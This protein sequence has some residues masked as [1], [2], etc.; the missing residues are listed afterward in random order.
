MRESVGATALFYIFAVFL[1]VIAFIIGFTINYMSAYR[2]NNFL[3]SEIE[4]HN[5]TIR[6]NV[7]DYVK[8]NYGYNLHVEGVDFEVLPVDG[9]AL[10]GGTVVRIKTYMNFRLPLIAVKIPVTVRGETRTIQGVKSSVVC[11]NLK[12]S[13]PQNA[14]KIECR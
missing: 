14:G 10:K 12:S 3:V 4:Q 1:I 6:S 8:S 9:S 7:N 11:D 13:L 5:G 2:A